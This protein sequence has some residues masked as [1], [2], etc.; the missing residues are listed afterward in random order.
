[1]ILMEDGQGWSN[2]K[3][4]EAGGKCDFHTSTACSRQPFDKST[5]LIKN[6]SLCIDLLFS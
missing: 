6:S 4:D 2:Y 1:M 5:N 3:N